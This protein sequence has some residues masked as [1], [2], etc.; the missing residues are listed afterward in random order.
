MRTSF[1]V[2][3]SSSTTGPITFIARCMGFTTQLFVSFDLKNIH[4]WQNQQR[5]TAEVKLS[6]KIAIYMQIC[7][8]IITIT[9][10]FD[11]N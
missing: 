8:E 7:V 3:F 9:S 1:G 10:D 5:A 4:I 2:S 6:V 11:S